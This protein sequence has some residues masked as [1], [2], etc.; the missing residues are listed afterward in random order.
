MQLSYSKLLVHDLIFLVKGASLSALLSDMTIMTY[1][2]ALK[3][4]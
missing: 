2:I 4:T 1:K 3:R